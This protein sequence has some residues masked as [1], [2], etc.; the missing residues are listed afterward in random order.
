MHNLVVGRGI[1]TN[2]CLGKNY[3][4]WQTS[5]LLNGCKGLFV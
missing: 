3:L 5:L 1:S 4:K 2:T